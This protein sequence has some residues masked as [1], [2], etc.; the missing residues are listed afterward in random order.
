MPGN[1]APPH[2]SFD[3]KKYPFLAI[4]FPFAEPEH[5]VT[6]HAEAHYYA[7]PE[8][9]EPCKEIKDKVARLEDEIEDLEK[10]EALYR[11][12]K[13]PR[14]P[15]DRYTWRASPRRNY[16]DS[17]RNYAYPLYK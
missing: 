11:Y 15:Y 2:E 14:Y 7:N 13:H 9:C 17:Y 8:E 16:G 3:P 12:P 5:V 10:R 1:E 6:E 4:E